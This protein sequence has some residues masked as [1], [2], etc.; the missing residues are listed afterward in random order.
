MQHTEHPEIVRRHFQGA[1]MRDLGE[2]YGVSHGYIG[3]VLAAFR[4]SVGL[5]RLRPQYTLTPCA[6]CFALIAAKAAHP[7]VFC[8]ECTSTLLN[9]AEQG[10]ERA[11]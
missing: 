8:A 4:R 3:K 11:S 7:P 5:D 6:K 10:E 1:S 2:A 9:P